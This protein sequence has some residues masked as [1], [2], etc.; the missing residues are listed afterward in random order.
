MQPSNLKQKLKEEGREVIDLASKGFQKV[1]E[2]F[3][4]LDI[5][6]IRDLDKNTYWEQNRELYSY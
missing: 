6:K 5:K 4:A 2:V 3:V 1:N